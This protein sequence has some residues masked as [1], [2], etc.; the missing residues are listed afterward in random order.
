MTSRYLNPRSQIK[1]TITTMWKVSLSKAKE[2]RRL[3]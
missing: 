2:A 1:T 3:K